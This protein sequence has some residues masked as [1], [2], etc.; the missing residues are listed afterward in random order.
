MPSSFPPINISVFPVPVVTV[1]SFKES[2]GSWRRSIFQAQGHH[3]WWDMLLMLLHIYVYNFFFFPGGIFS[4]VERI[5]II[6]STLVL[7]QFP[8][9][10]KV[11]C[12]KTPF[13]V[14]SFWFNLTHWEDTLWQSVTALTVRGCLGIRESCTLMFPFVSVLRAKD[15][16]VSMRAVIFPSETLEKFFHVVPP[17][18]PGHYLNGKG[19][20]VPLRG[21]TLICLCH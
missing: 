21:L 13:G 8:L 16:W 17:T 3:N 20:F 6:N 18:V 10:L 12:G 1:W 7:A 14:V 15:L 19:A 11:W 9:K 4:S 5:A 2:L